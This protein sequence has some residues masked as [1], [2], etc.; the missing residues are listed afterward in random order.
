VPGKAVYGERLSK[1]DGV[2][3]REWIAERSKLGAGLMKGLKNPIEDKCIVLYLGAASGTTVSHVSDLASNGRVYAVEFAPEP[4]KQLIMLA[5]DRQNIIPYF[6]DA[7]H[8]EEYKVERVDVLFQDIAQRNQAEI[9]IKNCA[10]YLKG[11]GLGLL[12]VK[13]RS[14]DV[15][16]R[17]NDVF[18]EV[19]QELSKKFRITGKSRLEPYEQDHMLFVVKKK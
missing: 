17:P 4:M 6:A 3:Y 12:V 19:E 1:R 8:P 18:R 16:R 13:S 14:I 9:F 2:E 7:N 10:V 5:K 11:S 15:T